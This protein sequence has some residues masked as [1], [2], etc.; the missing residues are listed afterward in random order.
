[1]E[2]RLRWRNLSGYNAWHLD[3]TYVKVNGV[4]TYIYRA[5]DSRGHTIDFY[6]SSRHNTKAAYR[7]FR[8][9]L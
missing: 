9:N 3:E 4:W 8:E 2:K 7:F 5:V 6:L 1:M